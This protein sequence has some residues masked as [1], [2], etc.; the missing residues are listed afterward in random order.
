MSSELYSRG[1]GAKALKKRFTVFKKLMK[2][3]PIALLLAGYVILQAQ[4]KLVCRDNGNLSF[5]KT[6]LMEEL[7]RLTSDY[8]KMVSYGEIKDYAQVEL[9]MIHSVKSIKTFAVVDKENMFNVSKPSSLPALFETNFD[10]AYIEP[11]VS[12]TPVKE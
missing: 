4:V 8:D 5:Q 1:E 9:A 3:S 12:E 10:L 6:I 11:E 2:Y 7:E